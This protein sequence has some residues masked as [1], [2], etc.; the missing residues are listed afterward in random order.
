MN[1][2]SSRV[3]RAPRV[4]ARPAGLARAQ[5]AR[6]RGPI[7]NRAVPQ[8]AAPAA[9]AA[10]RPPGWA[11]GA[12]AVGAGILLSR[13]AGLV[14]E[15]VIAHYLGLS[16]AAAAFRAALRIPNLLQNLLGEGVLSASFIPVYVKLVTAGHA[17][18]AARVAR[19][20]GAWLALVASLVAAAGVIA[21]GPLVDVLAP[22]FDAPTRALTVQLVQILFPGTALLVLSAWCLGVLNSHRRFFLSY[23][24]PVLWNAALIGAAIA[25]GRA[26]AGDDAAMAAWIAWGAV[27]GSAAQLVAQ[28]PAVVA[29]LRRARATAPA[30][31][32]APPPPD[33]VRATLRAFGPVVVG[34]GSVQISAYVD[35][36]LASFLGEAI[37]AAM[38]NAQT[39]YLL[40]VSLFGMAISAAELPEMAAGGGDGASRARHLHARLAGALRRGAFLVVP[41]AVAF[42]AIG[43]P[44]VALLFETGRFGARDTQLVWLLLAASSLGLFANAQGRLLA[45]AWYALGEPQRP[46]RAALA[47]VATGAALGAAVVLPL[48]DA[49]GGAVLWGAAGL[50]ATAAAGAWLEYALLARWLAARI[51]PL[52]IPRRLALGALGAAGLAGAVGAAAAAGAAAL[53]AAR[54]QVALAAVPAFGATYLGV[55]LAAG[56]PEAR[57]IARRLPGLRQLARRE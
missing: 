18:E 33:G 12:L 16:P 27:I 9:P 50:A 49:T 7:E 20:I 37:V 43:G 28:L 17:A 4:R 14:R 44:I 36:V 11:G 35:Q 47:R 31:G 8:P 54:W 6:P 23:A 21:A 34:R 25:A 57:A 56:V 29:I 15:R 10:P 24:A 40:P 41:S 32:A 55:M 46:L 52:P 38:A 42:V 2:T 30:P 39:L 22:G 3:D 53:G 45:S 1:R 26:L 51:G 5:L 13:I 19:A 48:A